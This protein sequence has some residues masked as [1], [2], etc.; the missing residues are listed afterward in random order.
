MMDER[1]F[2]G[3]FCREGDAVVGPIG[4]ARLR[5]MAREGRL[6]PEQTVWG[7]R[8]PEGELLAPVSAGEVL[9]RDRFAALVVDDDLAAAAAL[10]R[11][12]R[13]HGADH[14]VICTGDEAARATTALEPEAVFLDLELP[15]PAGYALAAALRQLPHPPRVVALTGDDSPAGR[16]RDRAAGFRHWLAKPADAER[17]RQ[18][19]A[20]LGRPGPARAG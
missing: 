19:L 9:R 20:H 4:R 14:C 1:P 8:L 11:L 13:E 7:Q 2:E 12:L 5:Q 17:L 18:L 10:A 3:W 16:K 15:C 6:R